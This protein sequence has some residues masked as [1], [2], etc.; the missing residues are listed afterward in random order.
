[1]AYGGSGRQV[2]SKL[3]SFI[4]NFNFFKKKFNKNYKDSMWKDD[5]RKLMKSTGGKR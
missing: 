3:V 1:M 2:L 5:L 4:L